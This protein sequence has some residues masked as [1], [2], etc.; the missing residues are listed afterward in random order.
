MFLHVA[1]LFSF[2]ITDTEVH[3]SHWHLEIHMF[4]NPLVTL[5]RFPLIYTFA[6]VSNLFK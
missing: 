6:F 4:V 2:E 5:S 3:V 1:I